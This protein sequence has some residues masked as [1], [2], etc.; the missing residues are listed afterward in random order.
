MERVIIK[1]YS[2]DDVPQLIE[3]WNK[4]FGDEKALIGRFF[5]LLPEMGISYVAE[6]S[7]EIIGMANV[8]AAVLGDKRCGYVYAVAV[9][10]AYRSKGVGA[11]LMRYCASKFPRLCTLPASKGL[12]AWYEKTLG[13]DNISR[14]ICEEVHAKQLDLDIK[15]LSSAEYAAMR[16]EF[17][18]GTAFPLA[19]YEYERELCR[20][21]GGGMFRCGRSIACG[22]LDDGVLHVKEYLGN[23]DFIP[24]LCRRLGAEKALVR[25]AFHAGEPFV[26]ANFPIPEKLNM[27]IAL[28]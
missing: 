12:Y 26:A 16:S 4:A 18:L 7:G 8:L 20:A 28:D 1:Q 15:N 27:L 3:L 9:D 25:T 17:K 24:E 2:K 6:Y 13:T 11:Q 21:Y 14:F 5:E 23:D 19:W 22:Y 10:E